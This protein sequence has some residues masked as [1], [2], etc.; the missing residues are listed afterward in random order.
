MAAGL[1]AMT[2]KRQIPVGCSTAARRY[3]RTWAT[4]RCVLYTYCTVKFC[5]TPTGRLAVV[6]VVVDVGALGLLGG[7]IGLTHPSCHSWG[8][9]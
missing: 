7:G 2:S 5:H 4:V 8:P 1:R 9:L 6:K 3:R